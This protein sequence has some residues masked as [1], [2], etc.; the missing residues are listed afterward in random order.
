MTHLNT[1]PQ[2]IYLSLSEVLF[3]MYLEGSHCLINASANTEV[4]DGGMLYDSFFVDDEKP[5]QCNA[6][7]LNFSG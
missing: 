6:L 5:S 1:K 2:T 4:V 7:C 3:F